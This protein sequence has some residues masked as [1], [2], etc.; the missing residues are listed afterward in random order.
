MPP[1]QPQTPQPLA[2]LHPMAATRARVDRRERVAVPALHVV[3][4]SARERVGRAAPRRPHGRPGGAARR[5]LAPRRYSEIAEKRDAGS[6]RRRRSRAEVLV[7]DPEG[8]PPPP[9]RGAQDGGPIAAA[10]AA[11][12]AANL[13][14]HA[15]PGPPLRARVGVARRVCTSIRVAARAPRG[16]ARRDRPRDSRGRGSRR[17]GPSAPA[18]PRASRPGSHRA[19]GSGR[20]AAAPAASRRGSPGPPTRRHP[21]LRSRRR[22]ADGARAP[23]R[24]ARVERVARAGER[25]VGDRALH[26][27]GHLRPLRGPLATSACAEAHC[28][29]RRFAKRWRPRSEAATRR[30]RGVDRLRRVLERH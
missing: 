4:V 11:S 19:A 13:G 8:V 23:T 5:A 26:R 9:A 6:S 21:S 20:R 16:R 1:R 29:S 28:W 10:N 15:M 2:V 30:R 25:G 22:S 24:R 18:A 12:A 17:G 7:L 27:V 14:P 3:S